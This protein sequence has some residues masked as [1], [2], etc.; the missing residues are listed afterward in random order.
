MQE[1][2]VQL[3]N[4]K[5]IMA[6][7]RRAPVAMARGVNL[8][9]NRLGAQAF[10]RL[11]SKRYVPIDRG[12]L[13]QNMQIYYGNL[14]VRIYPSARTPYGVFVHEGTSPHFPP[15]KSISRWAASHGINPYALQRSI[16]EKGTKAN[17]FFT[18]FARGEG[19][20]LG[21]E[22]S[23]GLDKIIDKIL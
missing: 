20:W 5:M 2:S 19:A 9:L 6:A 4:E 11:K 14:K 12:H 21:R 17:P 1:F 23:K 3:K 10:G 22:M 7:F 13:S 8:A 18:K 15:I 16:G